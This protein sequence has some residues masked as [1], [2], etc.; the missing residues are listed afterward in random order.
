VDLFFAGCQGAGLALAAGVFAGAFG[1]F[2][3]L[4]ALLLATAV[5]GGAALFAV[6]LT[7]EDHPGWPGAVAGAILAAF[8]F[9]V[10][11]GVSA[12]ARARQGA[13]GVTEALVALAALLLAGLSLL[14][15]P[16]A[17]VALVALIWLAVSRRRDAA[18]KYEG[19]RTLR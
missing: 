15:S 9:A 1:R 7:A 19:L 14:A 17:L 3:A 16:I 13:A 12:G 11:R 18:R 6:S 4:G 8:A 2:G 5:A 10:A